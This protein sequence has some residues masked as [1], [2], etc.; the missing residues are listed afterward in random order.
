MKEFFKYKTNN[1]ILVTA[2]RRFG[3]SVNMN[4]I[5]LFSEASVDE[6][7]NRLVREDTDNY[8]LFADNNLTIFQDSSFFD[9]HFGKYPVIYLDFSELNYSN[10]DLFMKGFKS[11]IAA[12]FESRRYLLNSSILTKRGSGKRAGYYNKTVITDLN[13][14][15]IR[16]SMLFLSKLLFVHFNYTKCVILIDEYDTPAREAILDSSC[17]LELIL[18]F[19]RN[20]NADILKANV[21]VDR[22]LINSCLTM[23]DV[24]TTKDTNIRYATFLED[25]GFLNFYG[26][27]KDEVKSL[28]K[29]VRKLHMFDD[30]QKWYGG[31]SVQMGNIKVFNP[32]SILHFLKSKKIERYW[33][34]SIGIEGIE[35]VFLQKEVMKKVEKLLDT[36]VEIKATHKIKIRHVSKLKQIV[37][38]TKSSVQGEI[39]EIDADLFIKYLT[40]LGYFGV[41]YNGQKVTILDIPNLELN[42]E[43]DNIIS[44]VSY[45]KDKSISAIN[46]TVLG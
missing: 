14:I 26:F 15:D 11:M 30:I 1:R 3:K 17:D 45:F 39:S 8:K 10:F 22:A 6:N 9:K 35:E 27:M 33:A 16:K 18:E 29:K 37:N 24:I 32:Y 46:D 25:A 7:G 31:Y 40:D 41:V 4:M 20:F 44:Y 5:K 19:I 23:G 13:E 42:Y 2:P 38:M 43:I 21:N 36:T 34:K 12:E 28:L